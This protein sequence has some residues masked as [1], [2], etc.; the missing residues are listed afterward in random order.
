[1]AS[2]EDIK[3]SYHKQCL[4]LGNHSPER[5]SDNY[6]AKKHALTQKKSVGKNR[7]YGS[8]SYCL[9][10][11]KNAYDCL[12]NK[13]LRCRYDKQEINRKIKHE[14][15]ELDRNP[16]HGDNIRDQSKQIALLKKK[17]NTTRKNPQKQHRG[18][19]VDSKEPIFKFENQISKK[20]SPATLLGN[21]FVIIIALIIGVYC[22]QNGYK[23][24][25]QND[26][27]GKD[28]SMYITSK[29]SFE[30]RTSRLG[31]KFF[32]EESKVKQKE[33]MDRIKSKFEIQVEF[34]HLKELQRKC[35]LEMER[36]LGVLEKAARENDPKEKQFQKNE[37]QK[38]IKK[39]CYEYETLI[40]KIEKMNNY[41]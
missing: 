22:Y 16:K 38:V 26:F 17:P 29:Y 6:Q 2:I 34:E 28:Y 41:Q 5:L 20:V 13:L 4:L 19:F 8:D 30:M 12:S 35:E 15:S 7:D 3:R 40:Q 32:I 36:I 14:I 21:K 39:Y 9:E 33:F 31:V 37:V 24:H 10:L 18:T 1:M 25:N 23:F 27:L 11:V